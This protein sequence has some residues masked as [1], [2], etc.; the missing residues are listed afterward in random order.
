MIKASEAK[1]RSLLA[2]AE[3]E[4]VILDRILK[5]IE[6]ACQAGH[7]TVSVP[8]SDTTAHIETVLNAL[9]YDVIKHTNGLY[10]EVSWK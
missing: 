10:T 8:L 4:K 5:D 9:G 7:F 1:E 2:R 6:R 3:W